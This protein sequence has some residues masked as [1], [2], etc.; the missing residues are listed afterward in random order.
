M[1]TVRNTTQFAAV[2]ITGMQPEDFYPCEGI[3]KKNAGTVRF[4]VRSHAM[5]KT[6]MNNG[7]NNYE[8]F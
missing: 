6:V 4:T 5:S 7:S 2:K 8:L 1:P 3:N